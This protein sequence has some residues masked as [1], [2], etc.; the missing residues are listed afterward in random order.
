VLGGDQ[1][2]SSIIFILIFAASPLAVAQTQVGLANGSR[3]YMTETWPAALAGLAAEAG[4]L[5]LFYATGWLPTQTATGG[6][7]TGGSVAL[8]LIGAIGVVPLVQMAVINLFK[9]PKF[10]PVATTNKPGEGIA[11][12]PPMLAPMLPQTSIGATSG[13]NLSLLNGTW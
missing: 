11:L 13:M 2:V 1:T 10:R 8:L 12:A 7:P 3:Y 6:V 5:G 9:V 4:V